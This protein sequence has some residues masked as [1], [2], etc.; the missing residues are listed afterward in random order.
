MT[1]V[2]AI[3]GIG[4]LILTE[5]KNRPVVFIGLLLISA[6]FALLR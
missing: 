3:V 5:K 2:D 1:I 6:L 4:L